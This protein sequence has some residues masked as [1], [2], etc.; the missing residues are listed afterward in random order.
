MG[1][2]QLVLLDLLR[3]GQLP[4]EL[5]LVDLGVGTGTSFVAVL[6]FVLALGAV[7]DVA[8]IALPLRTLRCA[9]TIARRPAWPMPKR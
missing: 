7:A 4:E 9:V 1:K 6:D 8:G 3:I 2:L 5:H